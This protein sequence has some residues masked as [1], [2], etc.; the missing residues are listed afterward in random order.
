MISKA[1]EVRE[2]EEFEDDSDYCQL[3]KINKIDNKII[4]LKKLY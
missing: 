2:D 1:Q 3:V 4:K